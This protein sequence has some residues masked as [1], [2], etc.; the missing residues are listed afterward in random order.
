M[1]LIDRRHIGSLTFDQCASRLQGLNSA[2]RCEVSLKFGAK[3]TW[4]QSGLNEWQV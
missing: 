2:E 1:R 3:R 4:S